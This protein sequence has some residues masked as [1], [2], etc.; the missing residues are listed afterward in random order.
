MSNIM[1]ICSKCG[2]Q[3]K[4]YTL[5]QY[6]RLCYACSLTAQSEEEKDEEVDDDDDEEK[7]VDE[8]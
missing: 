5:R 1:E 6:G 3:T 8:K 7:E 4:T 2:L